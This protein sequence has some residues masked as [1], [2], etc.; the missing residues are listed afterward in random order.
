MFRA[1]DGL[2][3][4]VRL[5]DPPLHEFLPERPA[6]ISEVAD[7]LGV[8]AASLQARLE[9]LH[10]SNPMMGHRG[11]RVGITSP[12][13]YRTQVRALFE[14]ACTLIAEGV[15]VHPEILIP[16]VGDEAEVR[17]VREVI[18]DTAERV[19]SEYGKGPRYTLGVMIE[20]PRACLMADS[21][22]QHCDAFSFGTND[23]TQLTYGLSRDDMGKFFADYQ[24]SGVMAESPLAVFDT[25][26][27]GQLVRMATERGRAAK[28]GLQVGVC[29][30]HGGDPVGVHF[31]H[32]IGLDY[33]SCS[34]YRVPVARLAAAQA[35]LRSKAHRP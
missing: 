7:D 28:P 4:T 1:M 27:V 14:A 24:R 29:G 2:P 8:R 19:I 10:E 33:V 12:E 3:V 25:A 6:D 21:I 15:E 16:L 20:L 35:A 9:Q 34:P 13:V 18:Y 11:V 5:L 23:L 17:V 32:E 30:E 22:A 26:G 31:F